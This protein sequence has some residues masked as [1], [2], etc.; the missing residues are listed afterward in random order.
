MHGIRFRNASLQRS[1][2][3]SPELRNRIG[4][5]IRQVKS[6]SGIFFS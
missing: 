1:V 6:L 2:E 3:P 4:Q 5:D